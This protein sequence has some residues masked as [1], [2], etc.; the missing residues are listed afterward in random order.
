MTIADETYEQ[1]LEKAFE[2]TLNRHGYGFQYSVLEL[3]STL[4]NSNS[5][6]W[7][8]EA[9]EFPVQVQGEGTHI[10]FILRH[11]GN[12]LAFAFYLLAECKRAN[13]SLS[14]WC[15]ARAPIVVRNRSRLPFFIEHAHLSE[16]R[17]IYAFAENWESVSRDTY[18]I[19]LEI[20]SDEKGDP[21]GP[22]RGV[23]KEALT[24][25]CRGLN[26]MI[27]FL[28]KNVQIL[29]NATDAYFLP[30]IFT[31]AQLW[32]SDVDL[33]SADIENG[34][35]DL[36]KGNFDKKQWIFYQYHVSPGLKHS[37][38][39]VDRPQRIG[40]LME[41]EYIRTIPIV[42]A[43]GVEKFLKWASDPDPW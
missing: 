34:N 13:P 29:G 3:A 26:G 21:G 5:S 42:T 16:D 43:S 15:F 23:I 33:G 18:Q 6:E 39:P 10:D 40:P 19:A 11:R 8:F 25:V 30:V 35:I 27:E 1:K 28:S 7:V 38:S 36:S 20:K 24:Q 14:N 2:K 12:R 22:G 32:A 41:S 9:A 17:T 31:T 37:F 4:C